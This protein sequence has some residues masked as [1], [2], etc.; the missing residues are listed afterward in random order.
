MKEIE[1][2]DNFL[3]DVQIQDIKNRVS[4]LE[5]YYTPIMSVNED[6]YASCTLGNAL[7][8][9]STKNIPIHINNLMHEH[10]S[11]LFNHTIEFLKD[12]LNINKVEVSELTTPGFHI[13]RSANSSENGGY[14]EGYHRDITILGWKPMVDPNC[15]Y[16]FASIIE[17]TKDPA[18]LDMVDE[19]F[20]YEYNKLVIFNGGK[21]LH[22]VG[23]TK[24]EPNEQRIT[25]QGH[26]YRLIN[27]PDRYFINF[28]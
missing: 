12:I 21:I 19:K 4:N 16:T 17:N 28:S 8:N 20:F 15:L 24:Y 22:K 2:F 18:Y 13:F 7:Y 3:T 5:K 25:Y 14:Q 1:A 10:F 9:M 6:K 26:I 11:D 27:E 23:K